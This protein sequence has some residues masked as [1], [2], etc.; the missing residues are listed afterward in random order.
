MSKR[1]FTPSM[2]SV[3][4]LKRPIQTG[5]IFIQTILPKQILR[6]LLI[7]LRESYE[8]FDQKNYSFCKQLQNLEKKLHFDV[9]EFNPKTSIV[10]IDH[11]FKNNNQG[12]VDSIKFIIMRIK[13]GMSQNSDFLYLFNI[14]NELLKVNFFT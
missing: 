8:H 2:V 11:I 14:L 3:A 6:Y 13:D 5:W 12:L 7:F 9:I 10:I 4:N 1:V